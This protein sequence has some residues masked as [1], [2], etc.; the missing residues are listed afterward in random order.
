MV[1]H[2]ALAF[3]GTIDI[4]VIGALPW[5]D[6]F[7]LSPQLRCDHLNLRAAGLH[8]AHAKGGG[9]LPRFGHYNTWLYYAYSLSPTSLLRRSCSLLNPAIRP[10]L[11][12]QQLLKY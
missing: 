4:S 12:F 1:R 10:F 2:S 5:S 6:H 11:L 3:A 8:A 9:W 7:G